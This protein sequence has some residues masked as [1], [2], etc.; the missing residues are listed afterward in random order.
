MSGNPLLDLLAALLPASE[1]SAL[2]RRGAAPEGWSLLLGLVELFVGASLLLSNALDSF[3]AMSD[4]TATYLMEVDPSRFEQAKVVMTSSGPLIWLTWAV[5]PVTWLLASI[6]ATGVARLVAFA[7][8]R[9][10]VGEPL[11]WLA[12]RPVQGSGRLLQAFRKSL[13][14]GPAR[15][16]R[17]ILEPSH[18][19][20]VLSC[21]P[22]PDWNERV[23]IEI[24]GRFYRLRHLEERPDGRWSVYAH[25]LQEAEPHEVIR[26][27]VRYEP[28]ASAGRLLARRPSPSADQS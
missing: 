6:P 18:D 28:P 1:R 19:L 21:R 7:V 4:A 27:L 10:A 17:I 5:R 23:T 14:F 9:E 11:V 12:L 8:S 22:K 16:D 25:G 26:R 24:A 3:Q 15:P 13:R 2:I 20:L